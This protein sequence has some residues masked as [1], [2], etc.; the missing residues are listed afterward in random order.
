MSPRCWQAAAGALVLGCSPW[1]PALAQA[2]TTTLDP[3][4][5][6]GEAAGRLPL[7]ATSGGSRLPLTLRETPASVDVIT[8]DMMDEL[9]ATTS[10]RALRAAAGVSAGQCFGLTCF[11]T[12]GFAGTLSLPLA[13][14]G[15]RYPGLA[16]SPRGTFNYERIEVIKGPSSVL[17][18]LGAVTG[19][20]NWVNKP[21][22]E[23][24]PR[25]VLL[26]YDR[27]NTRTI[28][29]GLGGSAAP[30]VA[31]RLDV[32]HLAADEGSAGFVDR[33]D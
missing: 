25:E 31:Y 32:S 19:L 22:D 26:G 7:E 33:S 6:E 5:V 15:V 12:R 3:V 17:H 14:D 1:N 23:R 4:V 16:M 24:A 29:V 30:A 18:G 10:E 27:W 9:G 11:S 28:G 2:T 8:R 13:I 21:A 20:V